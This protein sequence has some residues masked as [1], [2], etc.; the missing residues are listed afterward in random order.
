MGAVRPATVADAERLTAVH[1]RSWQAAYRGILPDGLLDGL[2]PDARLQWRTGRLSRMP[3]RWATLVV[4]DRGE[5]V[6]FA[7][8]GPCRDDDFDSELVGELYAIYLDP[9][10]WRRGLGRQLMRRAL[11]RLA[12]DGFGLATLWVLADNHGARRFYQAT[13]WRPDGATQPQRFGEVEL[14]EVRYVVELAAAG[15][16]EQS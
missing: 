6:G 5:V 13:G 14:T 16:P 3:P 15:A 8:T 10:H 2:A 11:V 7:D 12:A 4:E 9:D 1:V